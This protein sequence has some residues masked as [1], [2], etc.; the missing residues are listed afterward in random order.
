MTVPE[1]LHIKFARRTKNKGKVGVGMWVDMGRTSIGRE[2]TKGD[3][4]EKR[5]KSS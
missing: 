1:A 3:K 4:T 2:E 5:A